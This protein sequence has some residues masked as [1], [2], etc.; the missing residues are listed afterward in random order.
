MIERGSIQQ[1]NQ[2]R[3]GWIQVNDSREAHAAAS[4]AHTQI[5]LRWRSDPWHQMSPSGSLNHTT[6]HWYRSANESSCSRV[7]HLH[8]PGLTEAARSFAARLPHAIIVSTGV[9]LLPRWI[10]PR[11]VRGGPSGTRRVQRARDDPASSCTAAGIAR[12]ARTSLRG[13][14]STK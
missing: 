10:A 12:A 6:A 2:A 4:A 7:S 5:L 11:V 9:H 3:Q 1:Q 13:A 8:R 14:R